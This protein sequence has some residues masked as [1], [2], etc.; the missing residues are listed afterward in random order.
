M[1][2]VLMRHGKA[3]DHGVR[4]N[5]YQ[6]E[7]TA[8]GRKKVTAAARG[9]KYLIDTTK[10]IHIWSSPLPRARQ[11]AEIVANAL[12]RLSVE[13]YEELYTGDLDTLIRYWKLLPQEA[14]L[15]LVGHEPYLSSWGARLAGV[16]LPFKR[17][18]AAGFSVDQ[19]TGKGQL[20]WFAHANVMA[21]LVNKGGDGDE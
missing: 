16:I 13:E 10:D 19:T 9:M 8:K 2:L 12:G 3:E 5:D 15:I 14:T 4:E 11:T 18:T 17:A 7:L 1:E 6:R 20:S 21:E